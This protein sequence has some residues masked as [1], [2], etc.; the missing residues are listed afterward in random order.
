MNY[1]EWHDENGPHI[2]FHEKNIS[3]QEFCNLSAD[4]GL[5][6]VF[7][8]ETDPDAPWNRN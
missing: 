4:L 2:H 3:Y 5:G 6:D 1:I 7:V 8:D